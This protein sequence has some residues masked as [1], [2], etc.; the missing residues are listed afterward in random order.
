VT[1]S[2][3]FGV[4]A[5]LS[6]VLVAGMACAAPGAGSDRALV[7]YERPLL[8]S[9]A[10]QLYLLA[11]EIGPGHPCV[12]FKKLSGDRWA[13]Q[14]EIRAGYTTAICRD[15]VLF[16]FLPATVIAV[17]V[18]KGRKLAEEPWPFDWAAQSVVIMN[19]EIAA[20]GVTPTGSV[21]CAQAPLS[22]L[23]GGP[24]RGGPESTPPGRVRRRS[25]EERRRFL[26]AAWSAQEIPVAE[27]GR[28]VLVRA[29]P[30]PASTPP[31]TVR[32]PPAAATTEPAA[33]GP[34]GE[35]PAARP[36]QAGVAPATERVWLVWGAREAAG[37]GT[38]LSAAPL[39]NGT[40]GAVAHPARIG[41]PI[42]FDAVAHNG[43]AAI[44]YGRL[45]GRITHSGGLWMRTRG[46]AGWAPS[47]P[48][49]PLSN[50][51]CEK[52][53]NVTAAALGDEL[54]VVVATRL[55]LLGAQT[56]LR[57]LHGEFDGSR[58]TGPRA[59]RTDPWLNH[60]VQ[61]CGLILGAAGLIAGAFAV[62]ATLARRR[63]RRAAIAGVRYDLAPCWRRGVAYAADV[64]VVYS[65]VALVESLASGSVGR[66][67]SMTV[68]MMTTFCVDLFYLA[69]DESRH[70]RTIGKRLVGLFV[71][72]RNGG[73]PTWSEAALRNLL[74]AL[75]DS[76][77]VL[78][79]IWL[80]GD[81]LLVRPLFAALLVAPVNGLISGVLILNT[82]GSQQFGDLAAGTY[83][84]MDG[85]H[86]G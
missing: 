38:V 3:R 8:V 86:R 82:R 80:L 41:G 85:A 61:H 36:H 28:C 53:A 26:G 62:S 81:A 64:L 45:P 71:V 72:T 67:L 83:V 5:A 16:L 60:A 20:Y 7:R 63:P 25:R 13:R 68:V 76:L 52:T 9:A 50:P 43:R 70:G 34:R 6:A 84:V 32:A 31:A 30:V 33:P 55:D 37:N 4:I 75:V 59:A 49:M 57:L 22:E 44:I 24:V 1:A 2:V 54:H 17:R 18:D 35:A 21:V 48:V 66:E 14:W 74:R 56:S 47:R 12:C 77:W 19:G 58:W 42:R 23:W 11:Q 46:P 15:Y 10:G 51:F 27:A 29:V 73:Y 65:M 40:P 69:S 79:L 39:E 78:P